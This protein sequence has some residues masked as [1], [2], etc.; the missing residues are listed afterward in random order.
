MAGVVERIKGRLRAPLKPAVVIKVPSLVYP[1]LAKVIPESRTLLN[2][3]V[4]VRTAKPGELSPINVT[5]VK[6]LRHR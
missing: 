2:G 3:L 1:R 4:E 6:N 5:R